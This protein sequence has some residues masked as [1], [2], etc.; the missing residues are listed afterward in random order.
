MGCTRCDD[1]QCY[2][3]E[4]EARLDAMRDELEE[5][6]CRDVLVEEPTEETLNEEPPTL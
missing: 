1:L 5:C 2:I 3:D 4:L 6:T